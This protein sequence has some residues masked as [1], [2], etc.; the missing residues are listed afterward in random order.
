MQTPEEIAAGLVGLVYT[1]ALDER[2]TG[3]D[4]IRHIAAALRAY[5]DARAA[6]ERE[7]AIKAILVLIDQ[8]RAL[9]DLT[10][11]ILHTEALNILTEPPG[12]ISD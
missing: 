11:V 4:Y 3:L 2:M 10:A 1:E 9:G 6:Q 7:R 12:A 5:G 8:D